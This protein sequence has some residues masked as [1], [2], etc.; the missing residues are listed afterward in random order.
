MPR[1]YLLFAAV[2]LLEGIT[3]V[4]FILNVYLRN[5]L[6][7]APSQIGQML[8][9]GGLWFVFLKPLLGF[10]TDFWEG[11][12]KRWGLL[13]GLVCSSAGWLVI[14]G[15][16]SPVM[17]TL[18]I[19]LKVLAIA[20]L[21]V[22]IDGMIVAVSTAKNRSF[23]QSL[24]Y[25]C[26][27]GGGMLCA[28]WAG[29]SITESTAAFTQIF[30]LFSLL[31]LL[32]LIPVLIYRRRDVEEHSG[33]REEQRQAKLSGKQRLPFRDKLR[34]LA[35]PSFGWLLMLLFLFSLGADTSTY[36]EPLL[37]KRFS[38]SFLGSIYTWYYIGILSGIFLFPVLRARW[39]MKTLFVLSLFGWSAVEISCLG[40]AEWNGSLIYFGGGFF[41]AF[42][43][44]ALLTVAVAMCKI[45]GI[46]TFAFAFAISVKNLMDQS[47]V[48]IGGYVMEAVGITWLFVI[49]SLCGLLPFL[50]L[51]KL[52]FK[53][54]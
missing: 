46:E 39:G 22:L 19:S 44:I 33:Q 15:A 24:V 49:S 11:F 3:E 31:S 17:M 16:E 30:Y 13:F 9:L 38:G 52:D 28:R 12:N 35:S 2:Y 40:I 54:V 41:N 42:S 47:N 23:I 5:V 4:P 26:R 34:Q 32:I 48:L 21:D 53:E 37:E 18:G 45:R 36:F 20:F 14:A 8:F 29:A 27:F 7:F 1:L 25:G 50:V 43:S 10:I 6:S 51:H